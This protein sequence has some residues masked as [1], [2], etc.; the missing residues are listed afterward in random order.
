MQNLGPEGQ[1]EKKLN[2]RGH[3]G[4]RVSKQFRGFPKV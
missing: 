1:N 4:M 2:I 3:N